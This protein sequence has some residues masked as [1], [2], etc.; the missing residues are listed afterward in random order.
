MSLLP[1]GRLV[2]TGQC[3][4]MVIDFFSPSS[5]WIIATGSVTVKEPVFISTKVPEIPGGTIILCKMVVLS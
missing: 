5:V 4:N 2:R 3:C 1:K